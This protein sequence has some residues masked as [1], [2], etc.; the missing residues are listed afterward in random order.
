M[1]KKKVFTRVFMFVNV[2]WFFLSH[3]LPIAEEADSRNIEMSVFTDLTRK[4]EQPF[5]GFSLLQGPIRRAHA[6]LYSSSVELIKTFLLV[7]RER[8]DVI[9]A[10]TIKPIIFLGIVSLCLRIPFIAS[11]SGLGPA[12]TPASGIGNARLCI[13]KF[14]YRL[15]FSPKN[16]KVI[17][18]STHDA[19]VIVDNKLALPEKI[20]MIEGSGV[21]LE[22][23]RPVSGI[24]TNRINVLMASRLLADKGIVEFCAAAGVINKNY[25][26]NV[27]FK[28]AGPLDLDSPTALTKERV[29]EM[30]SSNG[31][32]FLGNIGDLKKILSKTNI[33]V[34][35]SY[36]GEGIPKVLIEAAASG[37]AVVT[38]DHPGCRDAILAEET[39]IL[40]APRDPGSLVIALNRLLEDRELM[41][42]MGRHGRKMAVERFCISRVIDIHYSLYKKF[43][44]GEHKS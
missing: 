22:Q 36:Y 7:R 28:L 15:I 41:I 39:G 10:V 40:A 31:V 32:Q 19:S 37:C 20:V 6:S 17:C 1:K 18:Q 9:H 29:I 30:C 34:M 8:P 2:D 11:I 27:S 44:E 23:Y 16:T 35:P 21:N 14:L 25:T 43:G 33:F 4:Y 42:S 24:K 38:T 13:I 26:H 5:K 3:R 12:F